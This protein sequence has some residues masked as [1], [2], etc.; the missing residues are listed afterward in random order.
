MLVVVAIGKAVMSGGHKGEARPLVSY[1]MAIA[2]LVLLVVYWRMHHRTQP[3]ALVM[4]NMLENWLFAAN[5]MLLLLAI[6]YT[7]LVQHQ[8][9]SEA[10]RKGIEGC[11]LGVLFGSW[12]IAALYLIRGMRLT[13]RALAQQ[14]DL[15]IALAFAEWQMEAS[16]APRLAD[17]SLRLLSCAWLV[18]QEADRAL[19]RDTS[20]GATIMRRRQEL[21]EEAFVTPESASKLFLSGARSVLALSQCVPPIFSSS[22]YPLCPPAL[23]GPSLCRSHSLR[24]MWHDCTV[25]GRRRCIQIHTA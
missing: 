5:V 6:C 12:L 18:S 9:L 11:M 7:G 23:G 10:V 8:M 3:Y 25:L 13:R 22:L 1:A 17:G 21:P 20:T 2:S 24:I 15:A 4:Q 19:E 16:I 14:P